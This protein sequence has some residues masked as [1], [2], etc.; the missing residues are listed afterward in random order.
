M[1]KKKRKNN[2]GT[3]KPNPQRAAQSRAEKDQ[4]NNGRNREEKRIQSQRPAQKSTSK[5]MWLR[6]MIIAILAVMVLGFI[7][8]PLLR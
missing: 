4:P 5:P 8:L 6:V 3:K 7:M 1:A 2:S